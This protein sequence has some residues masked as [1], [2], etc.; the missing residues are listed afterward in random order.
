ML[1]VVQRLE[2]S[3]PIL[4]NESFIVKIRHVTLPPTDRQTGVETSVPVRQTEWD[5]TT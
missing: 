1:V 3:K 4:K 5:I 2:V